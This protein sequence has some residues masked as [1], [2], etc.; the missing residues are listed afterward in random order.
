M[1]VEE[2]A[3]RSLFTGG[4]PA[5]SQRLDTFPR[6]KSKSPRSAPM[7]PVEARRQEVFGS[8]QYFFLEQAQK[9]ESEIWRL[10][11]WSRPSVTK[12]MACRPSSRQASAGPRPQTPL[13][14]SIQSNQS[15][16]LARL[17][18][19]PRS[20]Q[21]DA[22]APTHGSTP[23]TLRRDLR[24]EVTPPAAAPPLNSVL[25]R[26]A[27]TMPGATSP[28]IQDRRSVEL[29]LWSTEMQAAERLLAAR[30]T[31]IDELHAEVRALKLV[32][33]NERERKGRPE[34]GRPDT[35]FFVRIYRGGNANPS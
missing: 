13:V 30:Q 24:P 16:R 7:V 14:L 26:P 15:D 22:E 19:T 32:H 3:D 12:T 31:E 8:A 9:D 28:T 20:K 18:R 11:D 21:R 10:R 25:E 29:D 17:T 6:R 2:R 33:P 4:F 27:I 23:S 34:P 35:Q 5:R 1:E